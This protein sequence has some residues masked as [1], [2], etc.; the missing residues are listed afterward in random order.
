MLGPE[1][2]AGCI[3]E[4]A[5][6]MGFTLTGDESFALREAHVV[7]A[8]VALLAPLGF[9]EFLGMTC[10]CANRNSSPDPFCRT[11]PPKWAYSLHSHRICLYSHSLGRS[12]FSSARSAGT[13]FSR[14][15]AGSPEEL[16]WRTTNIMVLRFLHN[17]GIGTLHKPQNDIG[18]CSGRFRRIN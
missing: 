16:N 3:R 1:F 2:E 5:P 18:H 9:Q 7:A 15:A 8:L 17:C 14:T 11:C 4:A 13:L 10:S 12:F 6:G